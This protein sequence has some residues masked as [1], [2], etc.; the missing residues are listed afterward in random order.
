MVVEVREME[1]EGTCLHMEVV[2]KAMVVVEVRETEEEGTC[3]HM[4]VVVIGMGVVETCKH[5]V[6]E[7]K[8]MVVVEVRWSSGNE[9]AAWTKRDE[10]FPR[11]LSG[12]A[13][14]PFSTNLVFCILRKLFCT[15]MNILRLALRSFCDK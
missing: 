14:V 6:E 3:I 2:V 15:K 5:M 12:T 7:V 8:A 11:A 1:E 4:E 13:R 10:M 9:E